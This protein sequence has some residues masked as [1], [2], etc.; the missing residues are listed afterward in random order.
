M[1]FSEECVELKIVPENDQDI[2]DPLMRVGKIRELTRRRPN[3]CGSTWEIAATH[4]LTYRKRSQENARV[5][6]AD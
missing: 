4:V 5:I 6:E 1:L 3:K 2:C